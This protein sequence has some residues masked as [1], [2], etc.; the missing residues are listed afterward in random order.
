[1]IQQSLHSA[2]SGVDSR[3]FRVP[4]YRQEEE[5]DKLKAVVENSVDTILFVALILSDLVEGLDLLDYGFVVLHHI[6]RFDV[7]GAVLLE[8]GEVV[9][10]VEQAVEDRLFLRI[11]GEAVGG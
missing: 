9:A 4:A 2:D 5:G 6:L 10:D 3:C 8:D 11:Q 7:G 1:M